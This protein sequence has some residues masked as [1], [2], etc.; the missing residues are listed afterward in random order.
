[1]KNLLNLREQRYVDFA[2]SN[3]TSQGAAGDGDT[4]VTPFQNKFSLNFDGTDDYIDCGNVSAIPSATEL[5]VSF[6]A[7]TTSTT[8]NQVVFGDNSSSPIFSFEYWGSANRM[9]FEYGNNLYAYLTLTSVVTAGS[10]NNVVL[11]Y[12]YGGGS[13]NTDKI[14]FYVDGVDKSS[15]MSYVGTIPS[16]L[17]ASIGD[18]WIGNGQNYNIPFKG[19]IDE[20]AIWNTALNQAQISQVY[21]N[22]VP[23]DITSLSPISWWRFEEGSGTTAIDS[24][25]SND[26]TI[27]SATYSTVVPT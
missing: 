20:V 9:Y 26:G 15:S 22:G 21:N 17:N 8:R 24:A 25:G 7:N 13:G 3:S 1:M 6:W 10:W 4:G 18:F 16:S 27:T 12:N 5:S 11:V 23:N 2:N 14:K 19:K